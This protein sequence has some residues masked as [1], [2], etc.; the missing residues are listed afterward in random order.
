LD[1]TAGL[2][3]AGGTGVIG[4]EAEQLLQQYERWVFD[5]RKDPKLL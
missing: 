1:D 5:R 2:R 3:V 4:I